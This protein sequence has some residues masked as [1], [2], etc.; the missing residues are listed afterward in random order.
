MIN[1]SVGRCNQKRLR[2][3]KADEIVRVMM[4]RA[5]ERISDGGMV[6]ARDGNG[7]SLDN[8]SLR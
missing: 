7:K 5:A 8:Q 4:Q 1:L 3:P 2:L 6:D